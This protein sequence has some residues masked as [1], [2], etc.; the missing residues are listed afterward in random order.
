MMENRPRIRPAYQPGMKFERREKL[1]KPVKYH[2]NAP[3]VRTPI[4][5]GAHRATQM[6]LSLGSRGLAPPG[7]AKNKLARPSPSPIPPKGD[8]IYDVIMRALRHAQW[9]VEYRERYCRIIM[10]GLVSRDN[11]YVA[12]ERSMSHEAFIASQENRTFTAELVIFI[13]PQFITEMRVRYVWT[14]NGGD[15]GKGEM[16]MLNSPVKAPV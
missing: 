11:R 2:D 8:K 16:Q 6:P 9:P 3:T 1:S 12:K 5:L 14:Y 4:R 13:A 10:E 15:Y 7:R